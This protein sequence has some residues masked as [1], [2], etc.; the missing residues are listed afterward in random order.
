MVIEQ[1]P[2]FP[3]DILGDIGSILYQLEQEKR[4]PKNIYG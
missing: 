1:N 2:H 4:K 3:K